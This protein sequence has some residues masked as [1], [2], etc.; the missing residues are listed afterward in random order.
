MATLNYNCKYLPSRCFFYRA[1][2]A[3]IFR[4]DA[5][6]VFVVVHFPFNANDNVI[7]I[8]PFVTFDHINSCNNLEYILC[9]SN[10]DIS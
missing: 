3:V 6:V 10:V 7:F 5:E 8:Q 9:V 1:A 4:A 2:L